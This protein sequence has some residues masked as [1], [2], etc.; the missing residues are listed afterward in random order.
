MGEVFQ[1]FAETEE[2]ALARA[3][4]GIQESADWFR[5]IVG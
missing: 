3:E 4:A 1:A 5:P 2:E